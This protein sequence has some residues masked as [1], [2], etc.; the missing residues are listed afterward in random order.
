MLPSWLEDTLYYLSNSERQSV[1]VITCVG[2]TAVR[3]GRNDVWRIQGKNNSS[4]LYFAKYWNSEKYFQRE[5]LGLGLMQNLAF[6]NRWIMAAEIVQSAPETGLIVT[7][8]LE[9]CS[10]IEIL[11]ST[12]RIDKR[13]MLTRGS[14]DKAVACLYKISALI[15]LLHDQQVNQSHFLLDL[16]VDTTIERINQRLDKIHST[17][18][19]Y[20]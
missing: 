6:H 17:P 9:G 11:Q 20:F 12:F 19:K 10:F 5:L 2:G 13:P 18:R 15:N 8:G 1:R 14:R 7:K 16:S 4:L 3:I